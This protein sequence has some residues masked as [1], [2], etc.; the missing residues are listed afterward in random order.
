LLVITSIFS[1]GVT[2]EN[3][4]WEES[5]VKT[6]GLLDAVSPEKFISSGDSL[7]PYQYASLLR[8]LP[9]GELNILDVGCGA[10]QSS[11]YL[12]QNG[13]RVW[14]LE[15]NF[16]FC[17]LIEK[18]ALKYSL[19]IMSCHGVA[20]DIDKIN[21]SFDA[22]FFNASLHHCDDPIRALSQCYESLNVGGVLFLVNEN[23]IR[24]WMTKARFYHLMDTSP[25][26]M[27]NY[28]GNE[29]TY[30]NWE[31][32]QML[33]KSKFNKIQTIKPTRISALDKIEF[34]LARRMGEQRVH[35]TGIAI[36]TRLV[37]YIIEEKIREIS[38]LNSLLQRSSIFA[39]HF[40]ARKN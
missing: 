21:Q 30:Y 24:P 26:A 14:A 13:Y 17:S 23:F 16:R 33:R 3:A 39:C 34:I 11:V 20:E 6:D 4:A 8:Y 22:I 32:I 29:H 5:A 18:V 15:P 35:S 1:P 27:G 12:A 37:F 2:K 38:W 9:R 31:Y 36:L 7:A 28:G 19:P 10:G 40:M 25:E